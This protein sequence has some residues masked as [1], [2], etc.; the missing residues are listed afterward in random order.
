MA[1]GDRHGFFWP[2]QN[3]DRTY[4]ADS[5]EKWLKKFFSTGVYANDCRVKSA[6]GMGITVK[7]GYS[8]INGKVLVIDTDVDLTIE[9]ANSRYPRIDAV[10]IRRDN[11]NRE[12]APAVKTGSYNG[13]SPTAPTPTRNADIYEIVLAHIY[14]APGVVEITQ[15]NITDK[16]PDT[17]VCGYITS[18]FESIDLTQIIAQME[19]E[20]DEW[21]DYMKGQLSE[22]AAGRLQQEIDALTARIDGMTTG[23]SVFTI[24]TQEPTLYYQPILITS[25]QGTVYHGQFDE[26]GKAIISGITDIG[27]MTIQASDGEQTV[28][29][30]QTVV[31]YSN[32][33]VYANFF[34]ATIEVTTTSADL[35]GKTVTA[36]KDGQTSSATFDANGKADIIVRSAGAY[37]LSVTSDGQTYT[38]T[39]T[40][41]TD[42]STVTATMNSWNATVNISAQ[43]SFYGQSVLIYKGADYI[44]T[45]NLDSAG[46]GSVVLHEAGTYTFK[47]YS[48]GTEEVDIE[49]NIA[50]Q[51][52]Y[53][54]RFTYEAQVIFAFTDNNGT[55]SYPAGVDNENYTAATTSTKGNWAGFL[56]NTL[57][58]KPAMVKADGTLD[59]WLDPTDYTK[60]ADGT[61]SDYNN[62]S[63]SG[64]GAFA[65]IRNLYTKTVWNGA[66]ERT[67]YFSNK[68]AD[69]DYHR[70]FGDKEGIWIP[71]GLS[72]SA[73][74]PKSIISGTAVRALPSNITLAS[75]TKF[76]GGAIK[77]YLRD[78]LMMI[79]ADAEAIADYS[80]NEHYA[81]FG[82]LNGPET[83]TEL[84]TFTNEALADTTG[85]LAGFKTRT[86]TNG[87]NDGKVF[88]SQ[89]L[90]KIIYDAY[91]DADSYAAGTI[92][93]SEDYGTTFTNKGSMMYPHAT[94]SNIQ[95][96]WYSDATRFSPK[97]G[98][99]DNAATG[100]PSGASG[101]YRDFGAFGQSP[102]YFS[103]YGVSYQT[104]LLVGSLTVEG[105]AKT[106]YPQSSYASHSG[107]RHTLTSINAIGTF[108][109]EA[110]I[111]A[112]YSAR[113]LQKTYMYIVTPYSAITV[114]P[115]ASY[116]PAVA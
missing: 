17:T 40:V 8:N 96:A 13:N 52:T 56:E 34:Q 55:I 103:E 82:N 109:E 114:I 89:V 29:R 81:V 71:M 48:D 41:T 3:G 65:W 47:S 44:K 95:I 46:D 88:H 37:T 80:A 60:K 42:Q 111:V 86:N 5:F 98:R 57:Q 74:S 73:S 1:T 15:A 68:Q 20:F 23:G 97:V 33:T 49:V 21:F 85:G 32:Y 10:V 36:T 26:E 90:T 35:I 76:F 25:P 6:S 99:P 12:I 110:S 116:N 30:T 108:H 93:T 105:H 58:N 77:N 70:M 101:Y 4:G 106:A 11:I 2:S 112:K 113:D 104:R 59:Y 75:N 19:A 72:N 62:E 24:Y 51:T 66:N 84:L 92:R 115:P 31:Y 107:D 14:V 7:T 22:D 43:A 67:V 83:S 50:S 53:S 78:I 94:G 16:R 18:P 100:Y 87:Y 102:A 28:T 39:A 69:S 27:Q 54:I 63:Y 79:F 61:A 45:I 91:I 38:E 64:A 9:A